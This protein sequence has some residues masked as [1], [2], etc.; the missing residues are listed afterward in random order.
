MKIAWLTDLHL[1]FLEKQERIDFYQTVIK[2]K[3]DG[4]LI[5]GDS[6]EAPSIRELLVE[7]KQIIGKPIYFVLGNH[8]F[9]R[10]SVGS[11]RED[12]TR[13]TQAVEGLYWLPASG[14]HK[15]RNDVFLVGTDGF[16][17]GRY[18]NYEKSAVVLNDSYMIAELYQEKL[19]S[20]TQLLLKMQQLADEDAKQLSHDIEMCVSTH[21]PKKIVVLTHVQPFPEVC[22]YDGQQTDGSC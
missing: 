2:S 3:A 7:M 1:N 14:I 11:V 21:C 9:Y 8:D 6:A 5:S 16:A 13:L 18:G 4:V 19:Y 22:M 12:M 20:K 10:G 15:L 17:D